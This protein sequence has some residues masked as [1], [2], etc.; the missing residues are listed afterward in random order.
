LPKGEEPYIG[1]EVRTK[2]ARTG[3]KPLSC[4]HE[5]GKWSSG[6]IGKR[7][8]KSLSSTSSIPKR[9]KKKLERLSV[10]ETLFY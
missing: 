1:G 9:T 10:P 7:R 3:K 4:M 5:G 6:K 8:G 2:G